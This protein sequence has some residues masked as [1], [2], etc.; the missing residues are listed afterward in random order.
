LLIYSFISVLPILGW[1]WLMKYGTFFPPFDLILDFLRLFPFLRRRLPRGFRLFRAYLCRN[2][3]DFMLPVE[4]KTSSNFVAT[5]FVTI[6]SGFLYGL[7]YVAYQDGSIKA[8][9]INL[10]AIQDPTRWH[11]AKTTSPVPIWWFLFYALSLL[12]TWVVITFNFLSVQ[13]IKSRFIKKYDS[14]MVAAI[15]QSTFFKERYL[16]EYSH[17]Q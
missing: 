13:R 1:Q 10:N 11:I 15:V 6:F 9:C 5:V 16:G 8:D 17:S 3:M 14:E 2:E 7:A 4:K 12:W